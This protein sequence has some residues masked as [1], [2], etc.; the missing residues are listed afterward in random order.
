MSAKRRY[1]ADTSV[2]ALI[3]TLDSMSDDPHAIAP[4]AWAG[5]MRQA[6]AALS[7]I[8]EDREQ[9][10]WI[11]ASIPDPWPLE[12][13]QKAYLDWWE[14]MRGAVQVARAITQHF[15]TRA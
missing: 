13:L 8:S 1:A 6:S 4:A 3:A 14:K 10:H 9:L 2:A 12:T 5:A 7:A 15:P 11:V